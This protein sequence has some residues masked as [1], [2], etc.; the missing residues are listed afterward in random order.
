M[1]VGRQLRL[2]PRYSLTR[3][4]GGWMGFRTGIGVME[5]KRISCPSR[6]LNP[7]SQVVQPIA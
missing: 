2:L 7:E 3:C 6:K 1:E 5:K 4:T